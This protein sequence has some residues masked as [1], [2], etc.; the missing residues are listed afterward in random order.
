[1]HHSPETIQLHAKTLTGLTLTLH[2]PAD[3]SIE[4]ILTQ[5]EKKY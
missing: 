3:A 1:M 5:A 4:D 2:L